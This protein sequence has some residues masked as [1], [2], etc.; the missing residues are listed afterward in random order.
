MSRRLRRSG[1][2]LFVDRPRSW[3]T[4]IDILETVEAWKA[5]GDRVALATVVGIER[6]A[7]RDCGSSMA[8]N[9]RGEVAGSVSGGCV[10]GA[11]Y[12]EAQNVLQTGR[13]RLVSYGISDDQAV[14]VGLTCGGT[15]HVF[16]E[17]LE[18]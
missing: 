12:E 17:P 2:K 5:R 15:I 6:S 11:L 16:V 8:V 10:E 1:A 18:W 4:V 3:E 14:S 7:P 9:D 13:P